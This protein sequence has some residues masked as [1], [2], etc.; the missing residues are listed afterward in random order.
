M[1][2]CAVAALALDG[3]LVLVTGGHA[4]AAV[5]NGN[6]ALGEGHSGHGMDHQSG[7]YLRILQNSGRQHILCSLQCFLAGLEHELDRALNFILHALEQ[8]CGTKHHSG[9][10]VM[11]AGMHPAGI[12]GAEL[13]IGLLFYRQGVHIAPNQEALAGLLS[14][15]QN[16]QTALAAFLGRIAHFLKLCFDKGLGIDQIHTQ[17]RV[18]VQLPAICLNLRLDRQ[19]RLHDF[20]CIHG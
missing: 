15:C 18:T 20:L 12:L 14:T 5:Q 11:A 13:H 9:M 17:L 3:D 1:G 6:H 16:H 19:S 2:H 8:L 4:P 10:S 7:V